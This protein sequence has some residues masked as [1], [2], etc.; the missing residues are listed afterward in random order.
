MFTRPQLFKSVAVIAV[1]AADG[2]ESG[3][4]S[5]GSEQW[6][7]GGWDA[8]GDA[9]VRSDNSPA[10]GS[11]HVRLRRSTGDLQRTVDVTDL[12][13][14]RLQFSTKLV[15]FERSDRADVMVSGDGTN[16]TTLQS[17]F[18]GDDDGQYHAYDLAVPNVGNTLHLRF[19]AGM[20]GSGDYWYIDD[21]QVT[22]TL[23]ANQPPVAD[24]G[25][26]QILSD[27]GGNGDEFVMLFGSPRSKHPTVNFD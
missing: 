23:A 3:N 7:S 20:S 9:T 4:F 10:S 8:T 25:V 12:T 22:G 14:V 26:D 1:A 5:G 19:D 17:F 16:W 15:S 21:V 6:D 11:Q 18:N 13:D 2:F 27:A 24:A